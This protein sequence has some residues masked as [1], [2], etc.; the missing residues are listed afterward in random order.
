MT[1]A[2]SGF[3]IVQRGWRAACPWFPRSAFTYLRPTKEVR[4]SWAVWIDWSS[5][6][7]TVGICNGC[8]NTHKLRGREPPSV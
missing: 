2:A 4:Q 3:I 8:R 6:G 7:A 1:A 5:K